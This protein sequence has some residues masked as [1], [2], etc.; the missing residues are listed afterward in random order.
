MPSFKKKAEEL[1]RKIRRRALAVAVSAVGV[2][3]LAPA[4]ANAQTNSD[5]NQPVTELR[6]TS[7][8]HLVPVRSSSQQSGRTIT[9]QQAAAQQNRS[10][11][12]SGP[13]T[14]QE[15]RQKLPAYTRALVDEQGLEI[16]PELQGGRTTG[17]NRPAA[18]VVYAC[19]VWA[20]DEQGRH[21]L[22]EKGE[23]M[24]QILPVAEGIETPNTYNF[25]TLNV[26]DC[27]YKQAYEMMKHPT[28]HYVNGMENPYKAYSEY[29]NT[30]NNRLDAAQK[31]RNQVQRQIDGFQQGIN[32]G[33]Q[34]IGLI[35]QGVN[36]A[37]GRGW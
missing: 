12:V 36:M 9:Y 32:Q 7:D 30:I 37:R 29:A 19:V 21:I 33:R 5:G 6:M 14:A 3:S 23:K 31:K 15:I 24:V 4:Q 2:T 17:L 25:I 27:S 1:R 34:V 10:R 13:Q 26:I 18:G 8:G 20:K 11:A 28:N 35:E 22:N 16:V